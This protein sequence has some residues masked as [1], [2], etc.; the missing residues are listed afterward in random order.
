MQIS[1]LSYMSDNAILKING[2]KT[3]FH[4]DEGIVKAVDDIDL[5][6]NAGETLGVVGESGS[7]KSVT[8][9]SIMGLLPAKTAVI[10]AGEILYKEEDTFVDLSKLSQNAYTKYRGRHI[11]MIFQEPM[12]SLNPSMRCGDQVDEAILLHRT[13]DPSEAKSITLQLFKRVKLPEPERIYN[14][15]PHQLSGG[16]IQRVM[17]AM[18]ISCRPS[19]LIADEP[20]TALDVTVQKEVIELL[21]EIQE[22]YGM[23]I[24][25]IS[26]DLG[27]ISEIAD[28]VVV[29]Q[30]GKVVETGTVN[31]IFKKAEH[32]YTRGLIACRPPLDFKMS[33]LPTVGNF[34][35]DTDLSFE[36]FRKNH[37][38]RKNGKLHGETIMQ[39]KNL[40]TWYPKKR[41]FFGRTTEHVKA[42]QDVSFEVRK[43]E[44]LGL[45]G[46]SGSGKSTLS[47]TIMRLEKA[48]SGAVIYKGENVLAY[49]R[50]SLRALRKSLQIIFQDPYSSLNPRLT[51]G[52]AISEPMLV[53]KLVKNK[54]EAKAKT[55]DLLETVGLEARHFDRYPHEF[56]GGQRQRI[57]IARALALEPEFLICDECVSALDVSVQAQIINLLLELKEKLGLSYIFIS[58]DLAVVQFIS[59]RIMVMKEGK[60]VESADARKIIQDPQTAYTKKLL[61]SIPGKISS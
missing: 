19:L 53:H 31:S 21:K 60:I 41:D 24:L 27:V 7:G 5:Y 46:E 36:S 37:S 57:V 10:E 38:V 52:Y 12:T 25:F 30:K 44:C 32:P 8:S 56:S 51:V 17:I 13:K 18:A 28:R 49:D 33:R 22:E 47:K 2:L 9:L 14:A 4:T 39:V 26:H 54:A 48:H 58:H 16:Q 3:F 55:I 23:A 35:D 42:L 6:I 50:K 45:V 59:D 1:H 40:S 11:A 61:A 34:L 43:G 15:Y 29:M 20:T